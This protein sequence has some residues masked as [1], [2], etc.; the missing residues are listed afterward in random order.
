VK[1]RKAKR[2]DWT[3]VPAPKVGSRNRKDYEKSAVYK[4]RQAAA[5]KAAESR[6]QKRETAAMMVRAMKRARK[7]HIKEG[8]RYKA[9]QAE[10]QRI[11]KVMKRGHVDTRWLRA[12]DVIAPLFVQMQQELTLGQPAS[13]VR[14]RYEAMRAMAGELLPPRYN[15]V[16]D[17]ELRMLLD[18]EHEDWDPYWKNYDSSK[19]SYEQDV[20]P[21]L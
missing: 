21:S 6:R 14:R 11:A 1:K 20:E 17:Q 2:R 12:Y 9:E 8:R 15:D 3:K 19:A 5:Y 18:D 7:S 13:K 4:R 16:L 10:T